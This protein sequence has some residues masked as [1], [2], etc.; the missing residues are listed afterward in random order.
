MYI[1]PIH[2]EL[3]VPTLQ[4]FI[5]E[6]PLGLF[7]TA[8]KHTVHATIQTTHIPWV[9]DSDDSISWDEQK[10]TLDGQAP[11]RGALGVL[12]GHIA[13]ANPQTKVITEAA[14]AA[15]SAQGDGELDDEV[16]VLFNAPAHSYVSPRY[17]KQTKPDTGKVV[18][19]WN[20]SAVQVYGKARIYHSGP[21]ASSFLSKQV[22]DLTNANEPK[23]GGNWKVSDAP[24]RYVEL[25][26]KGIVGIEITIERIEGRYKM[27]QEMK[28]GDWEGVRDGFKD[29][30]GVLGDEISARV[31]EEGEKRDERAEKAKAQVEV[32]GSKL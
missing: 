29:M 25:L 9:L 7:T 16:L 15:A 17:Y 6:N 31:T 3:N 18:P 10:Q 24:E 20:Y 4:A 19:T 27:S 1:R 22:N 28:D 2:A 14:Q 12:R 5:R 32:E 8:I 26:K 30:G 13:R 21:S 11:P 23:S